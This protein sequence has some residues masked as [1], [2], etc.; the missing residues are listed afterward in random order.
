MVHNMARVKQ[1]S[2][3]GP[4]RQLC[5]RLAMAK[6]RGRFGELHVFTF[7]LTLRGIMASLR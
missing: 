4:L 2:T 6:P 5:L 1:L 7:A 3:S